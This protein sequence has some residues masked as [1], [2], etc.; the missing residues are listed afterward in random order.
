MEALIRYLRKNKKRATIIFTLMLLIQLT[1]EL[2]WGPEKTFR[3]WFYSLNWYFLFISII[4]SKEQA[5]EIVEDIYLL[6]KNLHDAKNRIASLGFN[7]EHESSQKTVFIKRIKALIKHRIKFKRQK[8]GFWI[9]SGRT[10]YLSD[11]HELRM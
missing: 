5:E 7:I 4:H 10:R 1:I 2:T 9:V 11:I 8:E 6:N 3:G